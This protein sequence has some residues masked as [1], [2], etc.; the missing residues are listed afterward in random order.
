MDPTGAKGSEDSGAGP[1]TDLSETWLRLLVT[2]GAGYS[3]PSEQV[4]FAASPDYQRRLLLSALAGFAQL[5]HH[6][7]L[8]SFSNYGVECDAW[9]PIVVLYERPVRPRPPVFVEPHTAFYSGLASLCAAASELLSTPSVPFRPVPEACAGTPF[10]PGCRNAWSGDGE[11]CANSCLHYDFERKDALQVLRWVAEILAEISAREL[12]GD[13]LEDWQYEVGLYFGAVLEELFLSTSPMDS[14]QTGADQGR[15]KRGV[16]LVTDI[17]TNVQRKEI[18]HEAVGM[19]Y[20]LYATVPSGRARR[21]VQ[22][23]MLSWYEFTHPTRLTDEEWFEM[24]RTR[25]SWV[26][27]LTPR[28]AAPFIEQ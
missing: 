17:Y 7:V 11:S 23:A 8:Y 27:S 3:A 16:S 21:V 4:P 19:P 26:N 25:I 10:T 20:H 1:A 2:L 24:L 18:L 5:K 28:W 15:M 14:G 6:T 22:G 13:P 9:S 12:A